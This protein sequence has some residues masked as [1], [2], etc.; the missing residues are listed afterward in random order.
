MDHKQRNALTTLR[1]MRSDSGR[2]SAHEVAAV[3]LAILLHQW[4]LKASPLIATIGTE[5]SKQLVGELIRVG[6]DYG[7]IEEPTGEITY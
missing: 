4:A 3:D 5:E 2:H 1:E 7:L 6:I